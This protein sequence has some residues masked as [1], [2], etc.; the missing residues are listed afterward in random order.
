MKRGQ[1][2]VRKIINFMRLVSFQREN[3]THNKCG[4][5]KIKKKKP[6]FHELNLFIQYLHRDWIN[7]TEMS[8]M[9]PANTHQKLDPAVNP[10]WAFQTVPWC[11]A[12][13][14][15]IQNLSL[16]YAARPF[17]LLKYSLG[18]T[19][20]IHHP[21]WI[22]L[23]ALHN[24]KRIYT[25]CFFISYSKCNCTCLFSIVLK[26]YLEGRLKFLLSKI[27]PDKT[28]ISALVFSLSFLI[29]L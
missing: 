10:E 24:W 13:R 16:F 20:T 3:C 8:T 25:F 18:I 26:T 2:K 5:D 7:L 22:F 17:S 4:S 28:V 19:K 29:N 23:G 12:L 11:E 1:K 6:K 14:E 27:L 21:C 9:F 15:A